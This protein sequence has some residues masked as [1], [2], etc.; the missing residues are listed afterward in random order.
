MCTAAES[1]GQMPAPVADHELV[2][3][4]LCIVQQDF[5]LPS[6]TP[7]LLRCALASLTLHRATMASKAT[8]PLTRAEGVRIA[9]DP[10]APGMAEKYGAP[11]ATDSEGFDPYADTVGPG[12]YGGVVQRDAAGE[13]VWGAQYQG[14]SKSPGPVY[15]GGGYT[16][17]ARL[18]QRADLAALGAW[19]SA[20]PDLVNE[21]STGGAS[22]LHMAGMSRSGQRAAALL[23]ERGGA[24]EA[25]DTYGYRPLHRMASNNLA[26]GAAAL[27]AAGADA[28]AR[29]R[30]GQT[31]LDVA[32]ESGAMDVARV[33]EGHRR[34]L[35]GEGAAGH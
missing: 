28:S 10:Y 26:E 18:V 33:L 30:G 16:P 21:V 7:M 6:C 27:L 34:K 3:A 32:R 35:A 31:A 23:A 4:R 2:Y 20:H 9:Y 15:A 14:H 19:L 25:V 29:T 22:P 13:V 1:G 5:G 8:A 24:V 17:T 12:I 11:G